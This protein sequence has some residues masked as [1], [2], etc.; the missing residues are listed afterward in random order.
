MLNRF[1]VAK[2]IMLEVER[3]RSWVKVGGDYDH[4]SIILQTDKEECKPTS[5]FKFN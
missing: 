5:Y 1:M 2:E 3:I 4:L